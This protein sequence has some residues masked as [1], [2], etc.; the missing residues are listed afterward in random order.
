MTYS[1]PE[2]FKPVVVREA[3]SSNSLLSSYCIALEAWRRGMRVT[4]KDPRLA[5][6]E[7]H[8]GARGIAFNFSRPTTLT[9]D[10]AVRLTH[11]KFATTQALRAA[12][13]SCPVSVPF[14]SAQSTFEQVAEAAD[15]AGYPVVIKPRKGSRGRGVL[16]G[17]TDEEELR[18]GYHWLVE[19]FEAREFVLEKHFEGGDHRVFVV[20]DQAVAAGVKV[21]AH[22]VGDGRHT[23]D[24][25]IDQKN[26]ER[27][28]NPYLGQ[29]PINRD[30]EVDSYIA[31]Q[32]YTYHSVLNDGVQLRL[33]GKANASAGGDFHDQT[34][35]L[36][37]HIKEAAVRSV[38]AIDGIV[39]AG[40]DIL[41]D[42]S[43]PPGED[44]V[45]IELNDR[46]HI[47][48]NMYPTHGT[49]RDVPAAV[50]DALFPDSRRLEVAGLQTL[51][52]NLEATTAPLRNRT[53][54]EVAVRPLPEDGLPVRKTF[55]V[56][57]LKKLTGNQRNRIMAAS[58]KTDVSGALNEQ[59]GVMVLGGTQDA[60]ETFCDR[61]SAVTQCSV[62][63]DSDYWDGPME[64]GF[65]LRR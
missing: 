65:V 3:Y 51:S 8:D 30:Y 54:A 38:A 63:E 18:A 15:R 32:G 59:H 44:Y 1:W 40:V 60:V 19:E 26:R 24:E 46:A 22:V 11:D 36:P 50:V 52:I 28:S 61:V 53:A 6:F 42:P 2:H 31:K 27:S 10:E 25:L 4:F 34:E 64:L 57:G 5:R 35:V 56:E 29:A 58:R 33:R 7:I 21:P 12:G 20:G 37:E 14:E 17:I 23:I 47:G 49:G 62:T 16:A 43:K 45:V 13:V 48:L 39:T 41:Y 55:V 9:A